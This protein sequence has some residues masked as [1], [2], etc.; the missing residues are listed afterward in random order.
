MGKSSL[1]ASL[2]ES[3]DNLAT[4]VLITTGITCEQLR[5]ANTDQL[6]SLQHQL[7]LGDTW[8]L[9]EVAPN[10]VSRSS[11]I[12][13]RRTCRL[14]LAIPDGMSPECELANKIWS[15]LLRVA[16]ALRLWAGVKVRRQSYSSILTIIRNLSQ[17]TRHLALIERD[18][19]WSRISREQFCSLLN[20]GIRGAY[21]CNL[22]TRLHKQG[23]LADAP[24]SRA[25]PKG[26]EPARDRTGEQE[27]V[28]PASSINQWQPF[29]DDF[30]AE[31]GRCSV[32]MTL[33]AGPTLLDA[34]ESMVEVQAREHPV[35]H[36]RADE[37]L[38][39]RRLNAIRTEVYDSFIAD[40][41]WLGPDGNPLLELPINAT[42]SA[43]GVGEFSWPP[44]TAH[45][46]K[47][48]LGTL[49][50]SHLWLIALAL[51]GR[52][53]EV[54][55]L[56]EG[57]LRRESTDTPTGAMHTWKLDGVAGRQHEAPLPA[58]A[59]TAIKQQE[60]LARFM[61]KAYGVSG[62]HLWVITSRTFGE[63][64]NDLGQSFKSLV[65]AFGLAPLLDGGSAHLH[66]IRKT[67]VRI[68]ALA[69]VHAPKILMDVLGHRDEQMTVMRY[70]LS[71][72]GL[73]D[74][75]QETVRE[76]V[77]LKGVEAVQKRAQLQGKAAPLLRERVAEYA[78]RVGSK[79]MEPQN[80]M[81]FVGAMTEGGTG[82]AVIAPG[83]ICTG[84]T[85]GG[86]CNKGQGGAN[87]HY[88]SPACDNQLV[89]SDYDEDGVK[90]SSAVLNAM[91]TVDYMLD[92]LLEA[93][94]NGEEMLI[95]QFSGQVKSMLGRWREVDHHFS[96]HPAR[97]KLGKLL[98]DVVLLP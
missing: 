43:V 70:I 27:H 90:V 58:M 57:C 6:L 79:A 65:K 48:I 4:E 96:S 19:F 61:K 16:I 38:S 7:L 29:P 89:M 33:S 24:T 67:L 94:G 86:V 49:Q 9:I 92:K 47:S 18:G 31:A 60:R 77:V 23:V 73:L 10:L 52:H 46:A 74:E 50:A 68:V 39:D 82:W 97:A 91:E 41:Q 32:H 87:P 93:N 21:N 36:S 81:E 37:G 44:R 75:I 8:G 56:R 28:S 69:L 25:R 2:T 11:A 98:S 85:R 66:R 26:S 30:T 13:S 45:Q 22:V 83:V 95:A 63:P 54:L 20:G 17:V 35:V 3:L 78:K 51:G 40:W 15:E 55:S 12:G 62:D 42:F 53:G 88:C 76:L 84:F 80:L 14:A 59:V 5:A 71:D 1:D 34:L 72:P 64:L